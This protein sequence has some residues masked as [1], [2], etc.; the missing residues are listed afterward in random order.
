M[1]HESGKSF[2]IHNKRR[3]QNDFELEEHEVKPYGEGNLDDC[4]TFGIE[5]RKKSMKLCSEFYKSDVVIGSIM[6][7]HK[8]IGAKTDKKYRMD[9]RIL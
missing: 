6:G 9:S 5:F 2:H 8:A 4:F 1:K 7:M 3:F